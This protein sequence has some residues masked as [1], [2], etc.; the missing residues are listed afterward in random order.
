[1]ATRTFEGREL[2]PYYYREGAI[3]P[4]NPD[5]MTSLMERPGPARLPLQFAP[6]AEG[7]FSYYEDE[8]NSSDYAT[9]Y[10]TTEITQRTADGVTTCVINPR[11]GQFEG[12]PTERAY[13]PN[14]WLATKLPPA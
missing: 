1:M 12:M 9:A 11:E 5:G 7:S 2:I 10:T 14:C 4:L 13:R 8:G 6:G 3:V